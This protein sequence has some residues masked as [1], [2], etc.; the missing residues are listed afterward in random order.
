M[1]V[2][3]EDDFCIKKEVKKPNAVII[4][5]RYIER[6]K[7]FHPNTTAKLMTRKPSF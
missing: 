4:D 6:N 3:V 1:S 7:Q 5:K 2:K